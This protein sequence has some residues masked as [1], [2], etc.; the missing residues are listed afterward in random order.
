VPERE[1]GDSPPSTVE[2][3]NELDYTSSPISYFMTCTVATLSFTETR[4]KDPTYRPHSHVP[5]AVIFPRHLA[6][7]CLQRSIFLSCKY[8]QTATFTRE[9]AFDWSSQA[10]WAGGNTVDDKVW[11]AWTKVTCAIRWT[12]FRGLSYKKIL[13]LHYNRLKYI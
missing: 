8:N 7:L 10:T 5:R 3:K 2:V 1:S 6:F 12:S 9:N 11:E 4:T 13:S